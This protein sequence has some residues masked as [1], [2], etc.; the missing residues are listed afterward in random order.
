MIDHTLLKAEATRDEVLAIKGLGEKSVDAI[1][2]L[3]ESRGLAFATTTPI[4]GVL[5][6]SD[7]PPTPP[8]H[9]QHCRHHG[10]SHK[11]ACGRY[12]HCQ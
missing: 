12:R 4:N 6:W 8:P 10:P 3:L 5:L 9:H 11:C 2:V 7:G 1:A